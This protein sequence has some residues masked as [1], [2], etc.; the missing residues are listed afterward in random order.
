MVQRLYEQ[1]VAR[2]PLGI[3]TTPHFLRFFAPYLSGRLIHW[4]QTDR[5][6]EKDW[7]RRT[8]GLEHGNPIKAPFG[9]Q[10]LGLFSGP[11]EHAE[12]S[13][14]Q[15]ERS[16]PRKD[17]S[18]LV[19]VKLKSSRQT[20]SVDLPKG[21]PEKPYFW[22]VAVRVVRESGYPVVDDVVYLKG[23]AVDSE[24]RLSQEL[25]MGCRESHWVGRLY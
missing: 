7:L 5:L 22:D 13:A 18:T 1:V 19:Y 12:P 14:F 6:C 21:P 2:R 24:S 10:E 15:I 23:E 4:I 25:T 17:G 3:S 9:W 8:G 11:D 16:E 20:Y